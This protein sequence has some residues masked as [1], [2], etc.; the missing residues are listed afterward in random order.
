MRVIQ[1]APTSTR[2]S[3]VSGGGFTNCVKVT[4]DDSRYPSIALVKYTL[5]GKEQP[6]LYENPDSIYREMR[7]LV[8]DFAREEI[9]LCP[10]R[11]F[12]NIGEIPETSMERVIASINKA[13]TVEISNKL[14]GSMQ[15]ARF[16]HGQ[17]IYTGSSAMNPSESQQLADGMAIFNSSAAHQSLVKDNP[18]CTFIFEYTSPSNL[19]VVKYTEDKLSLIGVRDVNTG[20]QFSYREMVALADKYGIPHTEVESRSFD[21]VAKSTKDY[22]AEEKEGWVLYVDGA[23][24]KMKCDD[25]RQVHRVLS[26][27]SA[28]KVLIKAIAD[29]Y[30][31]DIVS[32]VPGAYRDNLRKAAQVVYDY[33]HQTE[34]AIEEFWTNLPKGD[35][36]TF[37]M[38]VNNEVPPVLK[39]FLF[40]KY[41]GQSYS[42]LKKHENSR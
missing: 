39:R 9:V 32:K 6:D 42:I 15:Q 33:V 27:V 7:S 41:N 25:Y 28:P 12:F 38:A 30:F 21:E 35:R 2:R 5:V 16:Y 40:A 18:D 29:D 34:A 3:R 17:I 8:V 11:K 22:A 31:D 36:K 23:L 10:F 4:Q 1:E 13:Q 19:I 24:Y 37:A 20:R 14:D 26:F